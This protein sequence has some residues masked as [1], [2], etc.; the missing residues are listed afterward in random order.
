LYTKWLYGV[1]NIERKVAKGMFLISHRTEI[2]NTIEYAKETLKQ[3]RYVIWCQEEAEHRVALLSSYAKMTQT[4]LR[5]A[6]LKHK[7]V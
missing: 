4:P 7:R 5:N 6:L 3:R 2:G 1:R